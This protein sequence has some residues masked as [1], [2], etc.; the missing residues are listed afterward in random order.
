MRYLNPAE[1]ACLAEVIRPQYR[2]LVSLPS[3]VVD[4]LAVH[5]RAPG[6]PTTM[7]SARRPAGRCGSTGSAI[8]CGCLP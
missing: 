6:R 7:C 5:L 1:I 3:G 2:A 8:G 4:E